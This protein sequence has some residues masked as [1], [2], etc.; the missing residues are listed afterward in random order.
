MDK[1]NTRIQCNKVATIVLFFVCAFLRA[2]Y[3]IH[4]V[5]VPTECLEKK[6]AGEVARGES[7]HKL[8]L[9]NTQREKEV[10][11]SQLETLTNENTHLTKCEPHIPLPPHTHHTSCYHCPPPCRVCGDQEENIGKLESQLSLLRE[12]SVDH[13]S[14]LSTLAQDKEAVSRYGVC[15]VL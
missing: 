15:T 3:T 5:F 13:Q 1:F 9:E 8:A 6:L 7:T 14:L 4:Q 10:L 12:R 11:L 2:I